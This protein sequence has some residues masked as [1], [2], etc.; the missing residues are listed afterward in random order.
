MLKNNILR[1]FV[2]LSLGANI[3]NKE[4]QIESAIGYIRSM[5]LLDSVD[6]SPYYST[7]PVG[8]TEQDWFL[9][10]VLSGY[11]EM[12]VY[13]FMEKL[14]LIEKMVGRTEREKW[15]EREIDIDILFYGDEIISRSDL[16]V[17]HPR[18]HERRF[19]LVPANDIAPNAIHPSMKK[20]IN[21]LLHQ[22]E[23]TS[24]VTSF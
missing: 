2:L 20:T 21:Q 19:V 18:M 4:K 13:Y 15:H 23:D 6:I 12:D 1:K 8:Y 7:E 3:G 10:I 17:P 5:K 24:L 9:N 22:C 16:T 11:T 14:S